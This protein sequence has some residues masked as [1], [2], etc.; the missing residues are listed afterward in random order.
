MS[1]TLLPPKADIETIQ[2]LRQAARAHRVLGELKGLA[3]T[4]PNKNL[5]AS[6]VLLNES[7]DSSAIENIVTTH[8]ALFKAITHTN[9]Q[10]PAAKEVA[11]Y[12]N[13]LW[14][15][16]NMVKERG[17]LTTNMIIDLQRMIEPNKAGIRKIPGVTLTN[18][19]T[20]EVVYTPPS[21]ETVILDLMSN[22]EKYINEDYDTVDY[23]IKMAVIHYQFE[24][25]HPFSDGNGR[26]GRII[27]VLYLVL[28]EL[29]D[30]PILY[31]SSYIIRNKAG[32]YRLLQEV[33]TTGRW[34]DWILYILEG[35]EQT[36]TETIHLVRN[37]ND[38]V[39]AV[40]ADIKARLPRYYSKELVDLLFYEL[41]TKRVYIEKGLGV[42]RLTAT[43]YLKALEDAGFLESEKVGR[44]IIYRNPALL[45]VVREMGSGG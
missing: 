3:E 39:T 4:M 14:T 27:N 12:R 21:G 11:S 32:Y 18:A 20:G 9:Y 13:A 6:A 7:K 26:T 24:V 36:A 19:T 28:K 22:L 10:D 40:A 16:F 34:E 41:Y 23:L 38:T 37:I 15:G 1:V 43:T 42:S 31:L 44:E 2:T 29:L 5:L 33:T 17:M 8:D 25:I 45:G 30:S 35:I